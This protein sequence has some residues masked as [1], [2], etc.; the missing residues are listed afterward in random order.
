MIP[1]S[2]SASG[3]SMRCSLAFGICQESLSH[4][5]IGFLPYQTMVPAHNFAVSARGPGARLGVS[6]DLAHDNP[7]PSW[8][9]WSLRSGCT[10]KIGDPTHLGGTFEDPRGTIPPLQCSGSWNT[11]HCLKSDE[12]NHLAT[13]LQPRCVKRRTRHVCI[14]TKCLSPSR[15][16]G[17]SSHPTRVPTS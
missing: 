5:L 13:F 7:G 9:R 15:L 10:E 17:I 6:R 12:E 2:L 3:Y 16:V 4:S 14:S 8:R 1:G 11:G